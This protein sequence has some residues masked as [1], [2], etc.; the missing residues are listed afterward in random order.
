M[1]TFQNNP[2]I[3]GNEGKIKRYVHQPV[4]ID[5]FGIKASIRENGKVVIQS[6]GKPVVGS[7]NMIEYD[8]VEIPAS[9]IFKIANL[10][11]MTRSVTFVSI[12]APASE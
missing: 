1:P 2:T 4:T 9:L 7:E 3:A 11:K 6:A 8:E 10:L 5:H 12:E